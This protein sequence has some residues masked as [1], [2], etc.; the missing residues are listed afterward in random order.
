MERRGPGAAGWGWRLTRDD[1][2][3]KS[4][5]GGFRS[6]EDAYAAALAH[7]GRGPRNR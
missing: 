3:F 4:G 7:L 2:P 1:Q 5:P 6:A